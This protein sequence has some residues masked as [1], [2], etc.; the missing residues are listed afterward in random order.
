MYIDDIDER[1]LELLHALQIAPRVGWSDAGRIL[2]ANRATLAER[3]HRLRS[4]GLAWVTAHP[5][6]S[7]RSVTLALV[8][9]DCLPGARARVVEAVC[10][11]PRVVTVE[12]STRGRD[13]L[14]TVITADLAGMTAFLLDDLE[15]L[16][17]VARE[18]SYIATAVHRHG[19]HWRLNALTPAQQSAFERLAGPRRPTDRI[20]PPRDAWPLMEALAYDGRASAADLARATGRNPSTVRRQ[21]DRLLRSDLVSFRCEL[22][23]EVS[24]WS[25]SSTWRA[26]VEPA[27]HDRTI[28]ALATLPELRMC[29]S[30]TGDTNIAMSMWTHSVHD[31][32][33]IEGLFSHHLPWLRLRDSAVNLR[34]PKRMGWLLDSSGRA[35]GRVIPSTALCRW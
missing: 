18:R 26:R 12:E 30:T 35:T 24:G 13:M 22:A 19:T 14:L 5:G 28:A 31:M 20:A 23:A 6:G 9:V 15:T 32:R 34:T 25:V 1:D 33:R 4:A 29:V 27:D 8:E 21:L 10:G 3:W 2:G 7:Y 11:D 17:G 16:E